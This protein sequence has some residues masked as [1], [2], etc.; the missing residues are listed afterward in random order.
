MRGQGW[1]VR[2]VYP[3]GNFLGEVAATAATAAAGL[4][5]YLGTLQQQPAA[6]QQVLQLPID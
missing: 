4:A 2:D 6:A 5:C 3:C 1:S